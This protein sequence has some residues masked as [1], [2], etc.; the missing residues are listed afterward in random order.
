MLQPLDVSLKKPFK[1]RLHETFT[2]WMIEVQKSFT[3]GGSIKAPSLSSVSSWVD[4][5]W[6]ELSQQMVSCSLKKCCIANAIDGTKDDILWDN[7]KEELVAAE[8]SENEEMEDV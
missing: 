7:E 1:D 4:E 5:S 8:G 6:E 3:A 2:M